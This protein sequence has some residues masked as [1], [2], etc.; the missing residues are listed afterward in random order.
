MS[1]K[2]TSGRMTER[3]RAHAVDRRYKPQQFDLFEREPC[4]GMI[5]AP[6]WLELPAETQS[7]LTSLMVRLILEYAGKNRTAS[8]TEVRHDV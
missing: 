4:G 8:K 7:T 6:V 3:R 2:I 5:G 1:G